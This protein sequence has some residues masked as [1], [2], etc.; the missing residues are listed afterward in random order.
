MKFKYLRATVKRPFFAYYQHSFH[1]PGSRYRD[2]REYEHLFEEA[3]DWCFDR[4]G[5]GGNALAFNPNEAGNGFD[6]WAWMFNTYD[7][8][9]LIHSDDHAF[10][11]RMR[12]C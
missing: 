3:C 10:E 2:F 12:W 7:G 8:Q 9:F 4:W 11:F 6:Q 1:L 5:H